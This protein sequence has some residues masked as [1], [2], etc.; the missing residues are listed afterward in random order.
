MA[1]N[2]K[3]IFTVSGLNQAVRCHIEDAFPF[4]W[5]EGEL[6]NVACPA[7]GHMY[8][9]I[10]D[11]KAQIRCAMFRMRSRHL[12]FKPDEGLQVLVKARVSLYEARGDYQLIV[13]SMEERGDGALQRA[14]E[15]LKKQLA[16]EGLFDQ[17]HK[18]TLP[19][20]PRCIGVITSS[21]GAA[22]RD[23]LSVLARRF[24]SIPI[25]I[26][27]TSVQ[28]TE[29][30]GQIVT[31]LEI[32][33]RRQECDVLLLA[34]GG[35]SL[36]DL[37][38]FNEEVVARAIYNSVIPV[39]SGIGHE[40]DFTIADFVA[41]VRA[42][43]PSVAAETVSPNAEDWFHSLQ[44]TK[45]QLTKAINH[46]LKHW[47]IQL[48]HMRQQLRHPKHRL[49]TYEQQ[50]DYLEKNLA[51]AMKH[52]LEKKYRELAQYSRTLN[53]ISPLATLGRGYA[54]I[55]DAQT[56]T[57]I[58]SSKNTKKGQRIYAQLA[59]GTLHCEVVD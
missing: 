11:A 56:N 12:A 17:D 15:A 18:K 50:C 58:T 10:K 29:A 22:L 36:E 40:V 51:R 3:P 59:Q 25:I 28:G 41:D 33:N 42:P 39:V 45:D 27:P 34:R 4:V 7:S 35:G 19:L 13:E 43:T 44:H 26:Y 57:I 21:T 48:H 8:F 53:A 31:A 52:L 14:F 6:S 16:T 23:I 30:S 1:N 47:R 37:W 46:L 55:S 24:I 49:Q 2:E 54:I 32:A 5:V 9:S 20:L 38:P